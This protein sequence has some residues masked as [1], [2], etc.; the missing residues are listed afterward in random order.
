MAEWLEWR[1]REQEI[2]GS[3]PGQDFFNIIFF[4]HETLF[5]KKGFLRKNDAYVDAKDEITQKLQ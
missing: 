2:A 4:E 1:L 5:C 3:N